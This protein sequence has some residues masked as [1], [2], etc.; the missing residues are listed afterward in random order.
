MSIFLLGYRGSGKTTIGKRLADRLWQPFVDTDEMIVKRAGMTIKD[1][2]EKHG[3]QKF[4]DFETEVV[5]EVSQLD[6]H[7]IALGGGAVLREA[8]R[9]A[10]KSKP[11]KL[12]YLRCAAK[13]LYDRIHA[14]P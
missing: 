11:H 4:R 6:E 13:L 5:K 7:V 2:F 9:A 10:I 12:I 1:I 3:E 14:D 8:N